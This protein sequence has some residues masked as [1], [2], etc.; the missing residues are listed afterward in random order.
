MG[1]RPRHGAPRYA[2]RAQPGCKGWIAHT[3]QCLRDIGKEPVVHI[4]FNEAQKFCC[5]ILKLVFFLFYKFS[6]A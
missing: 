3:V 4:K 2:G 6:K 1:V 5:F